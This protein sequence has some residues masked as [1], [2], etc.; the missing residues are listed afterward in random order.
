MTIRIA[1]L[2]GI[3]LAGIDRAAAQQDKL[4]GE[5]R[6]AM[7]RATRFYHDK[8][9]LRGG[10]VYYYS[11]DLTKR[12]GEGVASPDQVWVQP[13]GTPTVG[14]AYLRAYAATKDEAYLK[15]ARD[16]AEALMYG[17]LQSG[18]WT[19]CVD[20]NPRGELVGQYRNGKGRGKNNST[21]DDGITQGAIVFLANLD[22]ALKFKDRQVHD[23]AQLAL[24]SLLKAQDAN[25]GFPQV[26]TKPVPETANKQASFPS[27]AWR[28]EGR[29][30]NYWDMYTLNDNV[31]GNVAKALVEAHRVYQDAR[32]Q[33]ALA[34][35]GDFLILAQLPE[36]Q[37]AWAQQYSYEMH[38]I[39]ARRFEPPAVTGGESQDAIETLMLVYRHTGDK[40]Y[41][42]P[43]PR[44][45][46]WLKSSQLADGR[47]SRYYELQTNRPLY[48]TRRNDDYTLTYDDANLPDH[49]GWKRDSHVPALKQKYRELSANGATTAQ[50][51]AAT[52]SEQQ[53]REVIA[54]LD[55]QGRWIST[56]GGEPLV[57]Q[58]K[59]KP[60]DKYIA[61]AVFS[62]N[63]E[64]LS[65][66]LRASQK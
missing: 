23:S 2:I 6:E 10:Y 33:T 3:C 18:G 62:R 44:A 64:L 42:E 4:A 11:T 39:W 53:I 17:Q 25:G 48:M 38:P 35:L 49:Y 36:P 50:P 27:Y 13:P 54:S 15:A 46:A 1:V 63:L 57:G 51:V 22:E 61:S 21:L 40:K 14:L 66:Y 55:A 59:F 20:F 16:A 52:P 5:A 30:K 43:I 19:N 37:P 65:H 60:G 8:V 9:A 24:E 41:L 31:C 12:L 29:I 32:Y 26:W 56:F 58:P 28:T 47:L 34:K 7:S 45:L